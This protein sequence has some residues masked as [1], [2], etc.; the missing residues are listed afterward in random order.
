MEH[1]QMQ[2]KATMVLEY[3]LDKQKLK[4]NYKIGNKDWI[5]QL[6]VGQLDPK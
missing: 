4:V 6:Q 2:Q 5:Q 1:R 3:V